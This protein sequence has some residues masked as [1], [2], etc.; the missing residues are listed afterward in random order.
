MPGKSCSAAAPSRAFIIAS[1]DLEFVRKTCDRAIII[2]GGI[3]RLFDD[4]N[5]AI[6]L[7]YGLSVAHEPE[8]F[9]LIEPVG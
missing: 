1:H 6:D 9:V 4:I 8:D 3:A 2:D 7:Y 5:L